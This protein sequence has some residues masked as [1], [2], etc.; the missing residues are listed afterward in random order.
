MSRVD[1]LLAIF[2]EIDW[3]T[4]MP[5]RDRDDG[6]RRHLD[7][8]AD[9]QREQGWL[10][11]PYAEP[12]LFLNVDSPLSEEIRAEVEGW[13]EAGLYEKLYC[14]C[15]LDWAALCDGGNSIALADELLYEAPVEL[16][17][18]RFYIYYREGFLEIGTHAIPIGYGKSWPR[19]YGIHREPPEELTPD[20][21]RRSERLSRPRNIRCLPKAA[22]AAVE[23]A[24]D[25]EQKAPGVDGSRG[26]P[27]ER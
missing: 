19:S 13:K 22:Q 7:R 8:L 24:V 18:N 12:H 20:Q 4:N 6:M 21:K 2:R 10:A 14:L 15:A 9:L 26:G 16:L 17:R 25:A 23:Q 1:T 3:A 11:M 27:E 5:I